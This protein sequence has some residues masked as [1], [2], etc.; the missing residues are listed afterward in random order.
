VAE[1]KLLRVKQYVISNDFFEKGFA[2]GGGPCKCSSNCC[3]GGV[4]ADVKEHELIL[5]RKELIKQHMDETQTTD[6]TQ[7]FEAEAVADSD[8]PSG[9]AIGTEVINNKCAFLDKLG[10][11]S[12]QLASVANGKHKWDGKPFYCVLFPVEVTDGV[13]GFD[14]MLQGEE[15]CCSV[16]HAFEA[17][18]YVACKEELT[19]L[20]GEDGYQQLE[21]HY[22]SLANTLIAETKGGTHGN[23]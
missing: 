7:W 5:S 21:T 4:W 17:P 16:S 13:V 11:C 9:R 8:F 10:R 2:A 14:P 3:S 6:E 1:E 15:P 22:A 23:S 12:I 19:Y 20:L 18:L